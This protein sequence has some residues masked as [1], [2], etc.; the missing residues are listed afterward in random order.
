[1]FDPSGF[2]SPAAF[3]A[4]RKEKHLLFGGGLH[5]CY[6][7]AINGVTLPELATALLAR[8]GV[9]RAG[10]V[11]GRIRYDGPFPDSLW[12]RLDPASR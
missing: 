10:P 12:L 5:R 2:T 9:R 4:D 7:E 1:M 11:R 8:P 6:G 3:Q